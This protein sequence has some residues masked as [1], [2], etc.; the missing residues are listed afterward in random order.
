MDSVMSST[1]IESRRWEQ[2]LR[3][4]ADEDSAALDVLGADDQEGTWCERPEAPALRGQLADAPTRPFP[5]VVKANISVAGYALSAAS[6]VLA[7]N[8]R[9]IDAPVVSALRAQ[10]A[11]VTGT[12]NMHELAY[13]ITSENGGFGVVRNPVVPG[14]SAGGSSGGSAAA[15]ARGYAPVALGTDT[16]GSVSIPASVCGVVGFR[17]TVGRWPG[18][19][20]V[21]LSHSRDTPGAFARNVA[22]LATVDGWIAGTA[23]RQRTGDLQAALPHRLG[24]PAELTAALDPDTA[25]AFAAAQER[26]AGA[27]VELVP[28]SLGPVLELVGAVQW[29]LVAW[30]SR[31]LLEAAAAE[32]LD[33]PGGEAWKTLVEGVASAD[34]QSLLQALDQE[35]PRLDDYR[36]AVGMLWQARSRYR[37]LLDAHRVSLLLFP[38]AP[39]PATPLGTGGTVMHLGFEHEVFPLMTRNTTAGTVLR[40]PMLT[41]PMLPASDGRPQGITL[42]GGAQEDDAVLAAAAALEAILGS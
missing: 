29:H 42:Q 41:Q 8:R 9:R 10:G 30:E 35:P 24:V 32:A 34:V 26:L 7:G 16:G 36:R 4:A 28:L 21:G 22:D 12:A 18:E 5:L 1:L 15:V 38:A 6:P 11:V 13:G 19:G 14:F 3:R 40:C 33:L 23:A 31:Q 37:A 17:P 2:L 39:R 20:L 25:A 27:G